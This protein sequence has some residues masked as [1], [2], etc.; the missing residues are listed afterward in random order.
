M[1]WHRCTCHH[2]ETHYNTFEPSPSRYPDFDRMVGDMHSR[3]VRVVLWITQ[4]VNQ[5]GD[6]LETG[7]DT[8]LG[9]SPNFAEGL[10]EGEGSKEEPMSTKDS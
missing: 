5:S 1:A 8:Y 3:G 6:D 9:P 2:W 7:G 4:M 10:R